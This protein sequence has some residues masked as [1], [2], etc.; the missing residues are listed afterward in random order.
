MGASSWDPAEAMAAMAELPEPHGGAPNPTTAL[1]T[2]T[3]AG[4]VYV[5]QL[6]SAGGAPA[7]AEAPIGCGGSLPVRTWLTNSTDA[8]RLQTSLK[9]TLQVDPHSYILDPR[10]VSFP[11]AVA[12]VA[13]GVRY[14]APGSASGWLDTA[15][16]L[17]QRPVP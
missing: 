16:L 10:S 17:S 5:W 13:S 2:V 3:A 14:A 9:I 6:C 4:S 7:A 12:L 15:R 8:E 1:A 11:D